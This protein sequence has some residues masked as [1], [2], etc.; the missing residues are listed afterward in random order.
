MRTKNFIIKDWGELKY[1]SPS[2]KFQVEGVLS[3]RVILESKD[4]KE[5]FH[6]TIVATLWDELA[7]TLF[8]VGDEVT[9]TLLLGVQH[10]T[11]GTVC[12]VAQVANIKRA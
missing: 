5:L 10:K 12:Q 7:L 9:A 1:T 8:F 6:D 2:D 11:D 3:R 4:D